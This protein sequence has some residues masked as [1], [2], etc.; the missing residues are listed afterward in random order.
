[1]ARNA[2]QSTTSRNK[3]KSAV[4]FRDHADGALSGVIRGVIRLSDQGGVIRWPG[5]STSACCTSAKTVAVVAQGDACSV[6]VIPLATTSEIHRYKARAAP[7]TQDAN[8][9]ARG[10]PFRDVAPLES[11]ASS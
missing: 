11:T 10:P 7:G 6:A 9:R 1:M 8:R 3:T 4:L 2:E 5:T